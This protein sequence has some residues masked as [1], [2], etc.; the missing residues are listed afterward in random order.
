MK[1]L[2]PAPKGTH[3]PR[4]HEWGPHRK[5]WSPGPAPARGG[6]APLSCCHALG[7]CYH[8]C[9]VWGAHPLIPGPQWSPGR[10][11]AP[12]P[13]SFSQSRQTLRPTMEPGRSCRSAKKPSMPTWRHPV[14]LARPTGLPRP[15]E[16]LLPSPASP[17]VGEFWKPQKGKLY[18]V[19]PQLTKYLLASGDTAF[20][21]DCAVTW[22]VYKIL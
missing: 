5:A 22:G 17:N 2:E 8:S 1:T 9:L 16:A 21:C 19:A 10:F 6:G 4:G 11:Q 13:H 7:T 18:V 14:S 15:G 3:K 20:T 12:P